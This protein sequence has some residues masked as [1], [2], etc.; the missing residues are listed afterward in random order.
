MSILRLLHSAA[1]FDYGLVYRGCGIQPVTAS[2]WLGR[3]LGD[4][5]R[6]AHSNIQKCSTNYLHLVLGVYVD[7]GFFSGSF[8]RYGGLPF[9]LVGFAVLLRKWKRFLRCVRVIV[10]AL[11]QDL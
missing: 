4:V 2:D 11:L 10:A 7:N 1:A 3:N 9:S 6:R 5:V 8:H